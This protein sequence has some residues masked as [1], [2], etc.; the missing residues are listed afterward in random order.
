MCLWEEMCL[1]CKTKY[2]SLLYICP[3]LRT[4]KGLQKDHKR[5]NNPS[6]GCLTIDHEIGG[7]IISTQISHYYAN[8]T[9]EGSS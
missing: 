4:T 3:I 8:Y 9:C 6:L 5:S 2:H 1:A 7:K